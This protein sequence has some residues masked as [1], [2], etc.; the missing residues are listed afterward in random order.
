VFSGIADKLTGESANETKAFATIGVTIGDT[1]FL[2]GEGARFNT[3]AGRGAC[4]LGGDPIKRFGD[5]TK[6]TA[7]GGAS[8]ELGGRDRS[9]LSFRTGSMS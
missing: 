7:S 5:V 4:F 3:A 1:A 2:D 8:K 6:A 9:P